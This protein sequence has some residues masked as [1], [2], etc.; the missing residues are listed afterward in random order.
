[1]FVYVSC[2]T[3]RKEWK[4]KSTPSTDDIVVKNVFRKKPAR[5]VKTRGDDGK[6]KQIAPTFR[7]LLSPLRS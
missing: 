7:K 3:N 1:M 6:K 4:Y 5:K 2:E